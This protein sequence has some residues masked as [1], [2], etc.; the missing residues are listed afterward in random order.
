MDAYAICRYVRHYHE[1]NGY[2]PDRSKLG[3][4]D[5]FVAL[6]IKN[7]IIEELPLYEGGP[8]VLVTLTEKGA[9]MASKKR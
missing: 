3:C 4:D 9:R 6:L 2:A 5:A 7:G 8:P 1:K